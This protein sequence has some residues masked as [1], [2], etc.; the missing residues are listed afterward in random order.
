MFLN[1]FKDFALTASSGKELFCFVYCLNFVLRNLWTTLIKK[2]IR[3]F[4]FKR[5]LEFQAIK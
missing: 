3:K 1:S 4:D 2:T 5:I